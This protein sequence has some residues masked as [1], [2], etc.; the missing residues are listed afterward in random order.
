[1]I[2]TEEERTS[3]RTGSWRCF[4]PGDHLP[5]EWGIPAGTPFLLSPSFAY[6]RELNEFFYSADMLSAR[7]ATRDGYARDLA[8][9]LNF[10]HRSRCVS[11][12]R[13]TT[14]EDHRAYLV[15]RR[16][17]PHGPGVAGATWNRE[18]SAQTRF[19]RWQ[20]SKGRIG[21]NP[22]PQRA[23]RHSPRFHGGSPGFT[24]ATYS[25]DARRDTIQWLPAASYRAWRDVGLRGYSTDGLPDPAFRGR[26]AA[27]NATF[28]DLMVRT[29]LRL[30]EQVSL[31]SSEVPAVPDRGY[32]RFWLPEAVAKA[33]SARWVYVPGAIVREIAAY[34]EID[35]RAIVDSARRHGRYD[36]MTGPVLDALSGRVTLASPDG[37][38]SLTRIDL[39]SPAQRLQTVVETEFGVEPAS[40][41]LS[42]SGTPMA[43]QTWKDVFRQANQRCESRDVRLRA[44]PHL[45]R[46]TFAVLTLEQL[47]RGHIDALSGLSP[48]QRTHYVRVFGDPL[49]WV[50]RALGHRSV[51]TTQ[52]YLHALEELELETRLALIPSEWEDPRAATSGNRS[53]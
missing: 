50:R 4:R 21:Q 29:G 33:G 2:V 34:V 6:D 49:D 16:H 26:W 51:T 32:A 44:H 14:E 41:W 23:R 20:V 25:H 52:V 53:A 3:A 42:E 28:A 9:F 35:R 22:V 12:W 46:H 31:L 40:L 37:L 15:W 11:D 43:A 30:T 36:R 7:P 5:A 1:M 10:L 13:H 48:Q 39:L 45:L 24:A 8:M 17:D 19:F 18:V 38:R 47:Q 27:R